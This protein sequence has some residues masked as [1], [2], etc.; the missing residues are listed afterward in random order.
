MQVCILITEPLPIIR[1]IPYKDLGIF[2]WSGDS[3]LT[4]L[5]IL[6]PYSV[7]NSLWHFLNSVTA[8]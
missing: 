5:G 6:T 4:D 8:I 7:W 3:S 1:F 2:L